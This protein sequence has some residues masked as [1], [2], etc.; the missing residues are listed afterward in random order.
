MKHVLNRLIAHESL[1]R[2]ES[3]QLLIEISEGI[4]D[5][6]QV[7][8]FMTI[9]MMRSITVEELTGFQEA[10]QSLCTPLICAEPGAIKKTPL[11]S[12]LWLHLLQPGL[13]FPWPNTATT[14]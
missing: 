10:L 6:H 2:E 8:S 5:T 3:R 13:G 12:P 1:S 14:E 9:F 11:T 4:Y 7:A